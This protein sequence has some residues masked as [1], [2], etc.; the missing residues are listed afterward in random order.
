[1]EKVISQQE[2]LKLIAQMIHQ[3]KKKAAGGSFYFLFWGYVVLMAY[4]GHYFLLLADFAIPYAVWLIT[5]PAG[6]VSGI[7]SARMKKKATVKTY[8]DHIYHNIWLSLLIPLLTTIFFG[9]QL[10]YENLTGMI[11]ML[12]GVGVFLSGQVMKFRPLIIGAIIVWTGGICALVLNSEVQYLI[13]AG[14][15][16]LGYLVPGYMLKKAEKNG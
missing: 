15:I 14:T 4:L 1:M 2:S 5:I 11:L 16:I 12:A 7:Y 3:A 8:T 9:G 6:I 10:G 13:G